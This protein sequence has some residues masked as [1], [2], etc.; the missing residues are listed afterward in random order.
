[1]RE[2]FALS[3]RHAY[4]ANPKWTVGLVEHEY[5]AAV[6]DAEW[7]ANWQNAEQCLR[8]FYASGWPE[9][10]RALGAGQWL[11]IDEIGSFVLDGVKVFAGPDFAWREAGGGATLVD[12]KTGAPRDEDREQVLG[13]ALYARERWGVPLDKVTARLVYLGSGDE[14]SVQVDPAALEGFR[15]HF[16]KSVGEMRALLRDPT[17][18]VAVRTDFPLTEDRASCRECAFRRPCG[19]ADQ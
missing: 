7:R 14:I 17:A 2:D 13:Y 1:M 4:R 3:R 5:A 11:P 12:W 8:R 10:A 15:D 18:N 6:P 19:R 16:R 9:R